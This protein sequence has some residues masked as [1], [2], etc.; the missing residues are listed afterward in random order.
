MDDNRPK[1]EVCHPL[2]EAQGQEMVRSLIASAD[3]LVEHFRPGTAECWGLG[4]EKL[5]R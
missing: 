5:K 3:V 1:Q 2:R 4:Y